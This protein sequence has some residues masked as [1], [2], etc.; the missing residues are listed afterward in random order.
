MKTKTILIV[1][2][3]ALIALDLKS[4]LEQYGYHVLPIASSAAVA[5]ELAV[6][7]RPHIILMDVVLKGEKNG[8]DAACAIVEKYAVPIIFI[9]GNTHL[10]G[11]ERLKNIPTYKILDKPPS[12]SILLDSINKMIV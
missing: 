7:K 1:E 5:V 8:I 2:D 11:D 3:E 6:K 4:N 12:E 9:T 10:L